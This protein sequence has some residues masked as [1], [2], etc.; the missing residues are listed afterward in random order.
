MSTSESEASK[1]VGD[2]VTPDALLHSCPGS[3]V[4]PE[5][6]V[7]ATGRDVTPANLEWARRKLETEGASAVEKILP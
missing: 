5:D 7:M 1:S 4:A 3:G 2:H 6:L